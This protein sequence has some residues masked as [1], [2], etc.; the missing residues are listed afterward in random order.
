MISDVTRTS[1]GQENNM[2]STLGNVTTQFFAIQICG[3]VA[4]RKKVKCHCYFPAICSH[5]A[6]FRVDRVTHW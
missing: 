6:K 1:I 2:Y 3:I 5:A 4:I